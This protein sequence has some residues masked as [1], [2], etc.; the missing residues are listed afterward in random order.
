MGLELLT[1]LKWTRAMDHARYRESVLFPVAPEW[2]IGETVLGAAYRKLLLGVSEAVVD[3]RDVLGL[4]AKLS[5]PSVWDSLLTASAGLGSPPSKKEKLGLPQLMPFVPEVARYACVLGQPR[6]RWDPG[7][8]LLTTL[9]SGCHPDQFEHALQG[10]RSALAV[11]ETDDVFAR[12]VETALR[13]A[14]GQRPTPPAATKSRPPAWRQARTLQ[15][16]PAERFCL[17]LSSII[18]LKPRL[19]RRQWTVAVEAILRV[20]LATH[21]LWLCRLNTQVWELALAALET[22][23]IPDAT[24]IEERCWLSHHSAPFLAIGQNGVPMIKQALQAYAEARIGMS[25][26]LHALD[27]ASVAWTEQ[28]GGPDKPSAGLHRFFEHLQRNCA[29]VKGAVSKKFAG[30]S[31]K[32][33]T[34]M[35]ADANRPILLSEDG[36]TNNH[37]E[38]IRYTL[39]QLQPRN[40]EL[41]SYD[42]SYVLHKK[43]NSNNSPWPVKPGPTTLVVLV[44]ACCQSANALPRS[45]D[46]LKSHFADYGIQ[47]SGGALLDGT[48]ARDLELLGLIIDSPDAAGGRLLVDPFCS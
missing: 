40:P 31:V 39:G 5:H 36:F 13:E 6:H 48:T 10:L 16:T 24:A 9:A 19:T 43:N 4:P 14:G 22:G 3:R 30:A 11:D 25:L 27:D 2:S 32:A 17:D 38:F 15:L 18:E 42:Q 37:F 44:S 23:V 20:G 45:L 28:V 8:L 46:D 35:I 26:L 29:I 21:V 34:S 33:A 47:A 12:F 1:D 41:Q 7:N